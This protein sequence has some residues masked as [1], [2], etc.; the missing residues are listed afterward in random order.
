M[1]PQ[2]TDAFD[3]VYDNE[4]VT[5]NRREKWCD[6]RLVTYFRRG[7]NPP[8]AKR[9]GM[10]GPWGTYPN[11]PNAANAANALESSK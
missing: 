7:L 1:K 8:L 9:F 2:Q 3:G 11:F 10:A 4:N 5:P 6:G